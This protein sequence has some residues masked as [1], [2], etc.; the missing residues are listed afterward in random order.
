MI[1]GIN[2]QVIEVTDTGSIYYERAIL[3]VKPQ[4]VSASKE[5]LDREAKVVINGMKAPSAINRR[6]AKRLRL[7]G[8]IIVAAISAL[9]TLLITLNVQGM[10]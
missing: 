6:R 2:R 8:L 9:M 7:Y 10:L 5:L 3:V 4:F 1:K